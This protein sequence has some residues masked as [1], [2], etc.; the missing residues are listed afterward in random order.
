M[1]DYAKMIEKREKEREKEFR[2]KE[3]RIKKILE[4][5]KDIIGKPIDSREKRQDE[6]L[7][8]WEARLE[9]RLQEEEEREKAVVNK[10]KVDTKAMLEQ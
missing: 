7:K 9:K 6:K 4:S 3:E 8:V 5:G 2:A 10:K 1:E